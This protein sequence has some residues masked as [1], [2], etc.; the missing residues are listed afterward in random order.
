[1]SVRHFLFCY[2][3]WKT[4]KS[5]PLESLR[6]RYCECIKAFMVSYEEGGMLTFQT[7]TRARAHTYTHVHIHIQQLGG[8]KKASWLLAVHP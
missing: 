3:L 7:H 2:L 6:H 1:M 4:L 5:L 8:L